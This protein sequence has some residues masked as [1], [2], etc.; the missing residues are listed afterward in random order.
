MLATQLCESFCQI[1]H[2]IKTTLEVDTT[3]T[4]DATNSHVKRRKRKKEF[5]QVY[6]LEI[7]E[8]Q[9]KKNKYVKKSKGR[10]QLEIN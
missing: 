8:I 1:Y 10:T 3:F 7:T 4:M 2:I 6:K 5:K 9:N